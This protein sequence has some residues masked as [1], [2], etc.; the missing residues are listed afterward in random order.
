MGTIP[1]YLGPVRPWSVTVLVLWFRPL[2]PFLDPFRSFAVR[3]KPGFCLGPHLET[4]SSQPLTVERR[5][6]RIGI[7][8]QVIRLPS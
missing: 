6:Q 7:L 1:G 3:R 4:A 5:C 2:P 8:I